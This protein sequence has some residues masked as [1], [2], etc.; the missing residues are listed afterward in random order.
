[1]EDAAWCYLSIALQPTSL[2]AFVLFSCPTCPL[3]ILL[4]F[5]P[6]SSFLQTQKKFQAAL[7]GYIKLI[8]VLSLLKPVLLQAIR[9]AYA[10]MVAEGIL[11][12]KRMKGYF[13]ALPGK[14][15]A[16]LNLTSKDIKDYHP[17]F[18]RTEEHNTVNAT[19][20]SSSLSELLPVVSTK[21][22][23]LGVC[24]FGLGVSFVY[25]VHP[26]QLFFFHFHLGFSS[27]SRSLFHSHTHTHTHTCSLES[28]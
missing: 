26:H 13:Q 21:Q 7:L 1:M 2:F 11:M 15:A 19:D 22:Q 17:T 10:E 12:K 5:T 16:Y 14:D 9:D 18:E 8:E 23:L 3:F 27:R 6:F 28:P 20:I 4:Y 24:R 25:G